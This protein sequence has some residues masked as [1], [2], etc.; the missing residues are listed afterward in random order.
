MDRHRRGVC[1]VVVVTL[2]L[3]FSACAKPAPR[4]TVG[5]WSYVETKLDA[6]WW[7]G[8][9]GVAAA[10]VRAKGS[11]VTIAIVDTGILPSH[12]DIATILPGV[13]TCGT[14]P[15]DTSDN[16]N[17]HG[18]QLAGIALGKDPGPDLPT[19]PIVVTKGVAPAAKLLPIKID[20]G[21]VTAD[22]LVNGVQKA[23]DNN[24]NVVLIAVGGYPAGNV[25]SR[26]GAIVGD[27]KYKNVLFVVASVWDDTTYTPPAWTQLGN[28]I[29]VAAMT[30]A[31]GDEVPFNDK[32]GAIW[33]PGRDIDTADIKYLSDPPITVPLINA[34]FSMQGTS[35]ASAIVAG[36][37]ALI[38][39]R[40]GGWSGGDIKN[41][42][43]T[44]A[45]TKPG[46][47]TS[48]RLDCNAAVP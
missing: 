27:E 26:L 7:Y 33:A 4:G 38:K 47:P 30:L 14:N 43:T 20:C 11:G 35:P 2:P 18:T 31:N 6:F 10:H 12:Q 22:S 8:T 24:A 23:V 45:V 5:G 41:A 29:L 21:L 48:G 19:N 15:S 32:R 42:L 16:T 39:E 9:V 17:G 13:A 34:P 44:K 3:L 36:C 1:F 28:A 40:Q 37:A 25:H 46:L